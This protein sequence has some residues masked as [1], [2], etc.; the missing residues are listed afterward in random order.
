MHYDIHQPDTGKTGLWPN[1]K[2]YQALL[3]QITI[4]TYL[5][6]TAPSSQEYLPK[7]HSQ[8]EMLSIHIQAIKPVSQ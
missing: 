4:N 2:H 8:T 6:L 3:S 7:M 1:A 5:Y